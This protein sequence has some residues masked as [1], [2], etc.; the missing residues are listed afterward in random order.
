[1]NRTI[2]VAFFAVGALL[3]GIAYHSTN[4]PIEQLSEAITGRYTNETI[5]YFA[6]GVVAIIG[7]GSLAAFGSQE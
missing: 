4:A 3:L 1:M 2:G 6:S 5:W 7:G